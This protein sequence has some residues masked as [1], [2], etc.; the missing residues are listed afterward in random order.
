MRV[1]SRQR[2]RVKSNLE[3]ELE[4]QGWDFL[5]NCMVSDG[6]NGKRRVYRT[7]DSIL[8]EHELKYGFGMVK[9]VKLAFNSHGEPLGDGYVAVYVKNNRY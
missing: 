7:E 5:L 3:K 6:G 2:Q 1:E 9:L 8:L 4:K